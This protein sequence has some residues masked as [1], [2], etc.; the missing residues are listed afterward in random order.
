MLF[1]QRVL[2][3][4]EL[5]G[6]KDLPWQQSK[7]PYKVWISEVMLQ[8]TQVNTVIPYFN[9]FMTSFPTVDD[10]ARA[11]L[12]SV[13]HHWTGLGYY[14][15]A[16]N[17]HKAAKQLVDEFDGEFPNSV[18]EVMK[19]S[20]IGRSTAGAILSLSKDIRAPILD[21][22]VKRVLA[23][24]QMIDGWT[25]QKKVENQLWT[26]ADTLTPSR[27]VAS[28]N[29]AMMDLGATICTRSKPVCVQCPL[30]EDCLSKQHQVQ[31]N[32]PNKKPK[33]TIP[34]KQTYMLIPILDS[35]VIMYQ[36]PLS[37][38]WGGLWSFYEFDTQNELASYAKRHFGKGTMQKSIAP[39]RHT[40]SHFHLDIEPVIYLLSKNYLNSIA[41]NTVTFC[42]IFE[43]PNLGFSAPAIRLIESLKQLKLEQ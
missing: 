34:V 22:N 8:Q 37:G 17:L 7:T 18:E 30:Q 42:H 28:Y 16:R 9:K 39:F 14:A 36:R 2:N 25:G 23:R 4:F 11:P 32:Y 40:F 19:L 20:G 6:R 41:D 5:H 10:L 24:H 35:D 12:D 43:L 26:L 38:I 3:W 27:N 29:Q 31:A 1:S 13:L 15:R 33:K 21:G